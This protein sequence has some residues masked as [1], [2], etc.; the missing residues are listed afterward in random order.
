[1]TKRARTEKL[2]NMLSDAIDQ[3]DTNKQ[4]EAFKEI[5]KG[6]KFPNEIDKELFYIYASCWMDW[7][8]LKSLIYKY[9]RA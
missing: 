2:I 7:D 6:L 4:N 1:M 8:R 3:N 9:S 5:E